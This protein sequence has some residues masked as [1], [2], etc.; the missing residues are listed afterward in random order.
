[1]VIDL[2]RKQAMWKITEGMKLIADLKRCGVSKYYIAK[3]LCRVSETTVRAWERGF[4]NPSPDN[5]ALL[6]TLIKQKGVK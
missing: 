6:E 2:E 5:R 4:F 3:H 1:M